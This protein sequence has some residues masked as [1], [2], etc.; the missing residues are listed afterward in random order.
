MKN[1]I[2]SVIVLFMAF[3][4]QINKK[5]A[6]ENVIINERTINFEPGPQAIVYKTKDDFSD[7]VPV[8]MNPERTEI[9]SYPAPF[10]IF[11]NGVLSK[12]TRLNNGYLLDNRGINE[13][14]VFL[15]YTYEEYANL[16]EAPSLSEMKKRIKEKFPLTEMIN[17]GLRM[18]YKNEEQE[19]NSLVETGFSGCKIIKVKTAPILRIE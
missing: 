2:L 3:S 18:Q 9:V 4:C 10:D 5:A 14:V 8:I 19:L 13:N 7:Y 1:T 11:Y 12:P 16:S 17:C 6:K 15:N